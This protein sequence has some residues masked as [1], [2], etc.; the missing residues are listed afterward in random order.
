MPPGRGESE[1]TIQSRCF[2]VR[3]WCLSTE[4][5]RD[6]LGVMQVGQADQDHF[7]RIGR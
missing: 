6:G 5:R 4:A 1:V 3:Q 2:L 7:C